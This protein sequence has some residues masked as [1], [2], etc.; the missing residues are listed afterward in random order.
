M[1]KF[2]FRESI[3]EVSTKVVAV[4]NLHSFIVTKEVHEVRINFNRIY[5]MKPS[6]LLSFQTFLIN[7][8]IKFEN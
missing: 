4:I 2:L 5:L 7:S 8:E 6:A 3:K 1:R